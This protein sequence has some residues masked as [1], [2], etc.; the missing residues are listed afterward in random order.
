MT[1]L[2]GTF[3]LTHPSADFTSAGGCIL[4]LRELAGTLGLDNPTAESLIA[5]LYAKKG[6]A[7]FAE[8]AGSCVFAH[9]D[10]AKQQLILGRDIFGQAA[11][12]W[13]FKGNVVHFSETIPQVADAAGRTPDPQAW[14]DYLALGYILPPCTRYKEV[15][16]IAAGTVTII[17]ADG[18]SE[19]QRYWAPRITPQENL[20]KPEAE[21]LIRAVLDKA[22]ARV[23]AVAP[24]PILLLSGGIDSTVLLGLMSRS[25]PPKCLTIGFSNRL[26]DE[27][28]AAA[29]SAARFGAPHQTV[30]GSADEIPLVKQR[31]RE[32]EE[33]FADSSLL[34]NLNLLSLA[35][36]TP[37]LT[38]SG[39][40][41]FF[42]GY[43]RYRLMLLREKLGRC[44][45][46]ALA[47]ILGT[48]LKCFKAGERRSAITSLKRLAASFALPP[49][50]GFISYQQIFSDEEI[51]RLCPWAMEGTIGYAE[52]M[53]AFLDSDISSLFGRVNCLDILTYLPDDG[54]L[55]L[56]LAS[57]GTPVFS[58][59]LDPD[60]LKAALS[61]PQ[62][63]RTTLFDTK[64]MLKTIG[65]EYMPKE[66]LA[67]PKK[68]FGIPVDDWFRESLAP[69]ENPLIDSNEMKRLLAE[70]RQG[71][72][73][74]GAKLWA[75]TVI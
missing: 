65:A 1:A 42:G 32:R 19:V 34:P 20:S 44:G 53:E 27:R 4:N 68:G 58:P 60:V 3:D 71:S 66:S 59:I 7:G 55:K 72:A 13:G 33:L 10:A 62:R 16:R 36:D 75:L 74:N 12:Y 70:H 5:T 25:K 2:T 29:A 6:I 67:V 21:E 9:Y 57:Q 26:Y 15:H 50:P 63:F 48:A 37:V 47:G 24:D 49:I 45:T 18:T 56:I 52:R 40:D 30:L 73:A 39:G 35:K 22:L 23:S 46:S 8:I 28:Q 61:L 14:R 69:A 54:C 31:L 38:G 41:E 17:R 11:L 43:R 51:R 64:V